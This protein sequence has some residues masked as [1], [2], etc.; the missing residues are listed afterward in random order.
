[1]RIRNADLD[2]F[3]VDRLMLIINRLGS[4]IEVKI[5]LRPVAAHEVH[6]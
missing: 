6:L 3:T 2:R 1:L 5:R 4:S